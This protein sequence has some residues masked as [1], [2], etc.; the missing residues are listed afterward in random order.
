[1]LR[2]VLLLALLCA[3]SVQALTFTVKPSSSS[4]YFEDLQPGDR[5][6]G[7]FQVMKGGSLDIDAKIYAP[8]GGVI[9]TADKKQEDRFSFGVQQG[10]PY[11]FCFANVMSTFTPKVVNFQV[12]IEGRVDP[13]KPKEIS[14]LE[15]QVKRLS[16][17]LTAIRNE[18]DYMRNR[19]R[20]HRNTSESTNA[21]VMWW[22]FAEIIVLIIVSISQ[23]LY[24]RRFF[25]VRPS[26]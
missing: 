11:K 14:E 8:D 1:M 17:G 23:I 22:A 20:T 9:Y 7:T 2:S 16:E 6:S 25:E 21:R 10:G 19:E 13:K 4:C 15:K 5:L 3:L 18:Q 24:L 26:V 12:H